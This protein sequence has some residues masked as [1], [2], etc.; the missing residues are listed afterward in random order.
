MKFAANVLDRGAM[1]LVIAAA[2]NVKKS[3][4]IAVDLSVLDLNGAS[5]VILFSI[6]A[7]TTTVGVEAPRKTKMDTNECLHPM[8]HEPTVDAI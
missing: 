2:T 5:S 4:V 8:I 1:S 7:Q 3:H 6:E